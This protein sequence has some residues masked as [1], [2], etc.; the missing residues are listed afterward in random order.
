MAIETLSTDYRSFDSNRLK[1]VNQTIQ[2]FSGV[3]LFDEKHS[4]DMIFFMCSYFLL[5]I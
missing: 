5:N 4:E 2:T 1:K 3:I